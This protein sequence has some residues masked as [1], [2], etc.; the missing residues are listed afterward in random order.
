MK[1]PGWDLVSL[2]VTWRPSLSVPCAPCCDHSH[3]AACEPGG[4]GRSPSRGGARR[5]RSQAGGGSPVTGDDV[6]GRPGHSA[7]RG[8]S[9]GKTDATCCHLQGASGKKNV[10]LLETKSFPGAGVRDRDSLAEGTHSCKM[11]EVRGSRVTHGD[12]G[13]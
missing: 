8:T 4:G 2:Q 13:L 10:Q 3:G 11:N 9:H 1:S 5:T 7:E 12:S 6:D